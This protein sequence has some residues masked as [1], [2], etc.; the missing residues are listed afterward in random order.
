[1]ASCVADNRLES[2]I[3]TLED[4]LVALE[5]MDEIRRQ[6]NIVFPQETTGTR[7]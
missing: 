2:P 6:L 7:L 1:L 4:S 3:R 5:A